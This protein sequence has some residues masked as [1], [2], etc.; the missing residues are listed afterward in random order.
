MDPPFSGRSLDADA[1]YNSGSEV[2]DTSGQQLEESA[3]FSNLQATYRLRIYASN[4]PRR[5][6]FGRLP[7][8]FALV[9]A[10]RDSSHTL[11]TGGVRLG[12]TEVI[13]NTKSPQWTETFLLN[14]VH[15]TQLFFHV[16][17][18]EPS[19]D[20]EYSKNDGYGS[21]LFEVADILATKHRT[22]ARRLRKGGVVFCQLIPV[23]QANIQRFAVF[24][25]CARDL[26]VQRKFRMFGTS[27]P[28]TIVK[29]E[30]QDRSTQTWTT[31]YR[32]QPV[33]ESFCPSWDRIE[34]DLSTLS[35]GDSNVSLRFTVSMVRDRKR[36]V[37]I[38][39]METKLPFLLEGA[40]SRTGSTLPNPEDDSL[41]TFTLQ[42]GT[43]SLETSGFL[44]VRRAYLYETLPDGTRKVINGHG[45]DERKDDESTASEYD[46]RA[47][48][49]SLSESFMTTSNSSLEFSVPSDLKT[50]LTDNCDLRVFVAID[51]TS[52]NGD[53]RE[54]SSL[55]HQSPSLNVYEETIATILGTLEDQAPNAVGMY[56][57]WGFGAKF[58]DGIVRHIFQCGQ[59]NC[60]DVADVLNAYKSVFS[61]GFCMS[62]PTCFDKVMQAAGV[63]AKKSKDA[64]HESTIFQYNVLLIITDGIMQNMEETRRQL[65]VYRSLPLSIIFV[66]VGRADMHGLSL[67]CKD[68]VDEAVF[69]DFRA[70]Q[71]NPKDLVNAALGDL[72][73]QI[74]K[75]LATYDNT[76]TSVNSNNKPR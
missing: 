15:G 20:K 11:A 56:T 71:N 19:Q 51:F 73:R 38:G 59:G 5:G 61:L 66:G 52:S 40:S 29:I 42:R 28:D 6:T 67:L 32:S 27:A 43:D 8:S 68:F 33:R 31:V 16:L 50:V 49:S 25:L 24:R 53:P 58:S 17:V 65:S 69:V 57:V 34:I 47:L 10:A 60:E 72:G 23:V 14:Y 54:Q 64:R 76:V 18:L 3:E 9:T 7:D 1:S 44:V 62:G 4:L 30:R 75:Y 41:P 45:S 35:H 22:R 48:S 39:M 26:V 13:R 36:S 46:H 63:H 37:P 12:A 2:F 74:A 21:A 55:H 70:V